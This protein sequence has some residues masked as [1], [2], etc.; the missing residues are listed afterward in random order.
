[1]TRAQAKAAREA[2]RT[3]GEKRFVGLPCRHHGATA[4]RLVSN[5]NC[6]ECQKAGN[7]K[8]RAENPGKENARIAKWRR[9]NPDKMK[10]RR[11][12]YYTENAAKESAQ[13]AKWR[14]E[15]AG[16][17]N[18]LQAERRACQLQRTPKWADLAAIAIVYRICEQL[19]KEYGIPLAVDHVIPL[20][21]KFV[22][23]LHIACNL[24]IIPASEN[25]RKRNRFDDESPDLMDRAHRAARNSRVGKRFGSALI[26]WEPPAYEIV[27]AA[28]LQEAA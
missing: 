4:L 21:G 19:E 3:R 14:R 25:S 16:K 15:N 20:Q 18:T 9:E 23:G 22:S 28:D 2:A 8:Y 5:N 1:M 11:A 10:S 26:A 27:T 24:Q 12:K 6:V 7:V 17:V 13:A